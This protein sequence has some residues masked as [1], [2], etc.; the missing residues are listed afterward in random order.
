MFLKWHSVGKSMETKK[1]IFDFLFFFH[2]FGSLYLKNLKFL[3]KKIKKL[4]PH[5]Y[6]QQ[7]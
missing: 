3:R 1:S 2:F 4:Y 7:T 5:R 6:D